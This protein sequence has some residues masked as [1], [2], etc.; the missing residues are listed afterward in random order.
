MRRIILCRCND[1]GWVLLVYW[2]GCS[3]WMLFLESI[4]G[5]VECR[6]YYCYFMWF[7]RMLW[8][9]LFCGYNGF[10]DSCGGYVIVLLY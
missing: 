1:V 6:R 8:V 9:V 7:E 5:R 3:V 4:G 10:G 2:K